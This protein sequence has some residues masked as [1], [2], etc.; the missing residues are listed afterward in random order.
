[1]KVDKNIRKIRKVGRV[2]IKKE[3]KLEFGVQQL[4]LAWASK[5]SCK[6]R[7]GRIEWEATG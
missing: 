6:G 5:A 1:M 3:E 7:M 2:R 4:Q